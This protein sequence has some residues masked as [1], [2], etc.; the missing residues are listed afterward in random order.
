MQ[1]ELYDFANKNQRC[2]IQQ[3]AT[4]DNYELKCSTVDDAKEKF[5]MLMNWS[6]NNA[7]IS[8]QN[9]L[10]LNNYNVGTKGKNKCELD[11]VCVY[12]PSSEMASC[13]GH[14]Q[15]S[16]KLS[17]VNNVQHYNTTFNFLLQ[18][19]TPQNSNCIVTDKNNMHC[20]PKQ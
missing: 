18:H 17:I 14:I 19:V 1:S 9:A 16:D 2:T 4:G 8:S 3:N 7:N 5:E 13:V 6:N 12:D 11:S 20:F 15:T 10:I